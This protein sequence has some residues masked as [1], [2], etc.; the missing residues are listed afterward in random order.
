[1]KATFS[2]EENHGER[3]CD[4]ITGKKLIVFVHLATTVLPCKAGN[5]SKLLWAKCRHNNKL[6]GEGT[7]MGVPHSAGKCPR[8]TVGLVF[9]VL[10]PGRGCPPNRIGEGAE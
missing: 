2:G 9:G 5:W 10:R 8:K 4:I 3:G 6:T 1:M 7:R